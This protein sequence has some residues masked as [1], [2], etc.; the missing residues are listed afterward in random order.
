MT[1]STIAANAYIKGTT[2]L[3]TIAI[4]SIA[5][6]TIR[7]NK[8][9]S[10]YNF[11]LAYRNIIIIDNVNSYYNTRIKKIIRSFD[12]KIRYFYYIRLILI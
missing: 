3:A 4:T 6:L 12:Y 5:D 11:F 9:L 8:L 10:L 2:D 1:L 7:N